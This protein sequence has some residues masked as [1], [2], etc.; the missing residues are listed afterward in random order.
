MYV[1]ISIVYIWQM[2]WLGILDVITVTLSTFYLQMRF[3]F[4][5]HPNKNCISFVRQTLWF[6]MFGIKREKD[7]EQNIAILRQI[8]NQPVCQRCEQKLPKYDLTV[9]II[10]ETKL[11]YYHIPGTIRI[12]GESPKTIQ[13]GTPISAQIHL[14]REDKGSK[15][16]TTRR[17]HNMT[18]PLATAAKDNFQVLPGGWLGG[19]FRRPHDSFLC[20]PPT[21]SK[22]CGILLS[23]SPPQID[24]QSSTPPLNLYSQLRDYEAVMWIVGTQNLS[25][26]LGISPHRG[27]ALPHPLRHVNDLRRER[28]IS[29]FPE[30][31]F[32]QG[33]TTF[34]RCK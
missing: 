7:T 12:D 34:T 30:T 32:P 25:F 10:K 5:L 27:T 16:R 21:V 20:A 15:D 22:A 3:I 9:W 31:G 13:K 14:D 11:Y 23:F 26:L 29:G 24:Q 28:K 1:C 4:R 17:S 19:Q 18:I 33:G 6:R 2:I 8:N